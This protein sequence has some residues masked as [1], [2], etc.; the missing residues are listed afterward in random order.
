VAVL[1]ERNFTFLVGYPMAELSEAL[2]NLFSIFLVLIPIALAV[3][4]FGGLYLSNVSLR[5][6]DE[7]TTRARRITAEN[8]DQT[9][10]HRAVNDE[11]GRLVSTFNDMIQRLHSSFAQ[12]RQFSADASHELRTPL[13]VMR[14]EIEVALRS[15]KTPEEYRR[16]LESS[17]E[18][19]MRM[20]LIIENLLTLAKADQGTHDLHFSEVN[21]A[22]LVQELFDDSEIL[23]EEKHIRVTLEK[24]DSITIVGDQ[25]RLRQL[26]LNIIDNAIKYT[27][28]GGAVTLS[29]ERHNGTALFRV[30]D[31]GIGIPPG[32]IARVFDRFY[33]VDKARSRDIGGT[34]LGLSIAKWIAELHRGTITIHSE[35]DRGSTFTVEL[36]IN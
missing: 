6:V 33:R 10:P 2:E 15:S 27:P 32:E 26:F 12:V 25:V 20:S 21:L 18:E 29:V 36:P 13:T 17:M 14:G 8:L 11:I 24:N 19:I 28:D 1:R 9:I 5:P 7:V 34:G 3:S 30:A 23:A 22:T 31:T 4:V 35:L 16:V